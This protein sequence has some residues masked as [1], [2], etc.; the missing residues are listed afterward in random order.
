MAKEAPWDDETDMFVS[1]LADKISDKYSINLRSLLMS[2]DKYLDR[3]GMA[4]TAKQIRDEIDSYFSDLMKGMEGETQKLQTEL[5]SAT[6]QYKQVD[7]VISGK[8]AVARIPY[9]RPMFVSRDTA[10]EELVVVEKYEESFDALIGRLVNISSYVADI[11]SPYKDF[12]IGSWLFSGAKNY[13]FSINPPVSP[14][15]AMENSKDI[16]ESIL[17]DIINRASG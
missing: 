12:K 11:S 15:L 17:D 2:P 9:V 5:E 8:A 4:D 7:S 16:I 14:V 10:K 13:V 6:S 1:D 3:K